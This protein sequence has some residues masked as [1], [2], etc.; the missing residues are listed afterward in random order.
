MPHWN[1]SPANSA[2]SSPRTSLNFQWKGSPHKPDVWK[3]LLGELSVFQPP[4]PTVSDPSTILG[5][6][7]RAVSTLCSY[8]PQLLANWYTEL[9]CPH[10]STLRRCLPST[11]MSFCWVIQYVQCPLYL[12]AAFDHQLWLGIQ[13]HGV[14]AQTLESDSQDLNLSSVTCW[15]CDLG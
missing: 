12:S 6:E 2:A 14:R 7:W 11:H 9:V 3:T 10:H 4:S 13:Q 8:H 1:G 5:G 15:L